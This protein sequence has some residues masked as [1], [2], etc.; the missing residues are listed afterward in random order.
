MRRRPAPAQGR[1]STCS[2]MVTSSPPMNKLAAAGSFSTETGPS[3]WRIP[4][5][6]PL[7]RTAWH[8]TPAMPA[9]ER[10]HPAGLPTVGRRPPIG[11]M[12]R[13]GER[14]AHSDGLPSPAGSHRRYPPPCRGDRRH[15]QGRQHHHHPHQAGRHAHQATMRT[16]RR[17]CRSVRVS[18]PS[19]WRALRC[20]DAA[21]HPSLRTC[22][23]VRRGEPRS[24]T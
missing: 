1:W 24:P 19:R 6:R 23:L 21:A 18:A 20:G 17:P 3:R 11:Q 13:A 10:P 7:E 15:R 8:T 4:W 9:T 12:W 2:V 16:K 14:Q 5:P 22:W